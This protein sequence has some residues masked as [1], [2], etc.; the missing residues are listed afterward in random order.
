MSGSRH[1][2]LT[3][4]SNRTLSLLSSGFHPSK[5]A[6]G[7]EGAALVSSRE[8][9]PALSSNLWW[10]VSEA[11]TSQT[12]EHRV[13]HRPGRRNR[14]VRL[15]DATWADVEDYRAKQPKVRH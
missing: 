14:W 12:S 15:F 11:G 13:P 9:S 2:G 1:K 8:H 4:L 7:C 10:R 6:R 3:G 5:S